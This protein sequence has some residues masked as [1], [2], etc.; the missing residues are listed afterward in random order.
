[1]TSRVVTVL[2]LGAGA[3]ALSCA[4]A[5]ADEVAQPEKPKTDLVDV[6][7]PTWLGRGLEAVRVRPFGWLEASV[8]ATP[9]LRS[10]E[11]SGRV[12][13]VEAD[14][15]RLHQAYFALERQPD[16]KCCFD[17]GG[18]VALLWGTD[19]RFVHARGLLDD[20]D[21]EE[22][23]DLLEAHALVRVP[24]ARGLTVKAGK[25]TTPM[26]YEVIEAPNDLLPS[27]SF[28]FGFAIPFT[29]TG[30]IATLELNERWKVGYGLVLGW[31]VWDDNNDALTHL[32]SVTWT[33]A[34]GRDAVTLNAIVGAEREDEDDDLRTVLDA[35]WTHSFC[36]GA[37]KT[38]LNADYGTEEG[39]APGG[40]DAT[41]WGVAGYVTRTFSDRLSAT[42]RVE[43]FRDEDGTRI[44][45][46]AALGEATF[47]LDWKPFPCLPNLHLRPEVR[48]DHSFD[49]P[50]FD[51][52]RDHD[53]V[54]LSLDLVFT[55]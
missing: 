51:D 8:S 11:R 44:G 5:L 49:G 1:M 38:A 34:S 10:D 40:G 30:A 26:G 16:P 31:D 3:L 39:A 18:K 2:A 27:R 48:W 17:V 35:T 15:F 6:L 28:L 22:Q 24:V 46:E 32:G 13:D 12:F 50:F 54:S 9:G 53:Q 45:E 36:D 29:H 20:Q 25:C 43:Y 47:G 33:S 37:W 19:A 14:G 42:A 23:F 52:G 7:R 21:D 55:F 4:R 41:W